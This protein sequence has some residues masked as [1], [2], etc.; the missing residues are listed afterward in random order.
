MTEH[1][2]SAAS[3]PPLTSDSMPSE[4]VSTKG[5]FA[6]W[7]GSAVLVLVAISIAAAQAPA[8]LRLL[9]L[10][11]IVVGWAMG[12]ATGMFAKA[13]RVS[14]SSRVVSMVGAFAFVALAASTWQAFRLDA[15]SRATSPREQQIALNLVRQ[16]ERDSGGEIAVTPPASATDEFREYLARRVRQLGVWSSPWPEL[17]WFVELFA[18]GL[19]AAWGLRVSSRS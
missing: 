19:A 17:F 18:G 8:R 16:M 3:D 2:H 10:F 13:M 7:L 1:A 4:R 15:A 6:S 12:A 5:P 14:V 11:P 9:V